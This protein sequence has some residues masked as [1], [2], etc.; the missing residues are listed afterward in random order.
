MK[1]IFK[2]VVLVFISFFVLSVSLPASAQTS[3]TLGSQHIFFERLNTEDGLSYPGING[4]TQDDQGFIWIAT[5]EGLNRYDGY[6]FKVYKHDR[7]DPT[8]LSRNHTS[9]VLQDNQNPDIFW[10][11]TEQGLN[12]FDRRTETFTWY[13]NDPKD[14][15]SVAL[16]NIRAISQTEDG[17]L[18]VGT[19]NE[20]LDRFDPISETFSHYRHDPDDP[21]SLRTNSIR[22]LYLDCAGSLWVAGY[23][24]GISRFDAETETFSHLLHNPDNPN[25]LPGDRVRAFFHDTDGTYWIG[26]SRNGLA[27]YDPETKNF[28]HYRHN[29][30]DPNSL[31]SDE[32]ETILR[33][34]LGNLWVGT[35]DA[36][37]NLLDPITGMANRFEHD[38]MDETSFAGTWADVLFEDHSGLIW[39]GTEDG[40]NKFDPRPQPFEFW[41]HNPDDE[42]TLGGERILAIQ[43]DPEGIM[44]I[45]TDNGLDRYDPKTASFTHFRP[46]EEDPNSLSDSKVQSLALG[47]DGILWVGTED[48]LNRFDPE[49]EIFT[50]YPSLDDNPNSPS[51]DDIWSL[52]MDKEG[53]LWIGTWNAGLNR[54]D[55]QAEEFTRYPYVDE[56]INS[57]S[58][59]RVIN[60]DGDS[61][62]ILWIVTDDGLN[63]FDPQT[64]TFTSYLPD[65][66]DPNTLALPGLRA[67]YVDED[68]IVWIGTRGAGLDRY[69]PSTDT[70]THYSDLPALAGGVNHILEDD[71]GYLWL[72]T[73]AGIIRFDKQTEETQIFDYRQGVQ[74]YD[75]WQMGAQLKASDGTFYFG[76]YAGLQ[77]FRP[78][79]IIANTETAP[80][81]LTEFRMNNRPVVPGAEESPIDV[82]IEQA[83]S[84]TLTYDQNDFGFTFASLS[85]F[86]PDQNRFEYM[87]EGFHEDWIPRN[88]QQRSVDFTGLQPGDYVF[89][90][91]GSN[92]DSIWSDQEVALDISI[93][94]PWWATTW[95]RGLVVLLLLGGVVGGFQW[96]TQAMRARTRQLEETVDQRTAELRVAKEAAEM[97]DRAK[98]TFLATM[99]HELRTPLNSILGYAQI[100]KRDPSITNEQANGLKTI[101]SS[102]KHLL[103]LIN[104]VL[105]LSKVEAGAVELYPTDF[106]LPI[107]LHGIGEIVRVRAERKGIGFQVQLSDELPQFVHADER[108]LRQVLLNILGNAVKFTDKGQVVL[109]VQSD[110]GSA[111]VREH[112]GATFQ[113]SST[114]VSLLRFEVEDTGTGISAAALED[115]FNPFKQAG[116]PDR[117]TDGTGLGLAISHN[118]VSLLG[119]KLQVESRLGEGSRFWFELELPIAAEISPTIKSQGSKT[120]LLEEDQPK[121]LVVD[122]RWENRAVFRD[123]LSPMGFEI[124]EAE[125]GQQALNQIEDIGPD[126]IIVDLVMPEMDG[127]EF[128]R[129]TKKLSAFEHVPIIA[130]SAS[131]YKEDQRRSQ[132]A[133]GDTF[134]P[135]PIDADLLIEQLGTLL[136]LDWELISD[137]E[138]E[139]ALGAPL[140]VHLPSHDIVEILLE[141]AKIGNIR[142][143]REKLMELQRVDVKLKPFAAQLLELAQGYRLENIVELLEIYQLQSGNK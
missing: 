11:A 64:E 6:E 134:L 10:V 5:S 55:L 28:Q 89:R 85:F 74:N 4:I 81:L 20:G 112:Q 96:R 72:T 68:G 130:T 31:G 23:S 16:N 94:P 138:L 34:R 40:I 73:R 32:I 127:F 82:P 143:L 105:D 86:A 12:K 69:D 83:E 101:E 90:V 41:Q 78:H 125:N 88:S 107:F 66:R 140:E 2:S 7:N 53:V 61:S 75:D 22:G 25:S 104:D 52:F 121:I 132:T 120:L 136:N 97:A 42:N 128:I 19:H 47:A 117:Q 92:N 91:R 108:R 133:G 62:G 9:A 106:H 56:E 14:P 124:H 118:L 30:D 37:L 26:T 51:S 84:L 102:G 44:W 63:S 87:L 115:I 70:F 65:L 38:P 33:D 95:F 27:H 122:D 131:V 48:Q 135:K 129:Q 71:D 123:L 113:H 60:I 29:S 98:S 1:A 58:D 99:S 79:D 35:Y 45:G 49:T 18:W 141:L 57:L 80:V 67:V 13:L 3:Q 116:A 43:E 119:G 111:G 17:I 24:G 36:G 54:F 15:N 110:Q 103:S 109:K 139:T 21:G 93:T 46:D 39:V 59:Q 114:P 8:S 50:Q 77:I 76:S 142:L 126:A 137:D 100:V